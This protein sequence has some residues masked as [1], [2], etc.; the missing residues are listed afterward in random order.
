MRR[1]FTLSGLLL[2]A[3]A[4]ASVVSTSPYSLYAT[5]IICP[6]LIGGLMG[7]WHSASLAGI[8][9]GVVYAFFWATLLVGGLTAMPQDRPWLRG[10]EVVVVVVASVLGGHLGGAA[11]AG[12]VRSRQQSPP[13]RPASR[14]AASSCTSGRGIG[15]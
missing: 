2:F 5:M 8:V 9:N 11:H 6:A 15:Q 3:L 12:S 14:D 4:V 1:Q 13:A 7:R 10:F